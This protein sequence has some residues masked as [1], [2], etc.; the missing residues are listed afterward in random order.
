MGVPVPHG[1]PELPHRLLLHLDVLRAVHL[2]GRP[3][4]HVEA[5]AGAPRRH[6]DGH[7]VPRRRD[8]Q[9]PRR[10]RGAAQ[11][12]HGFGFLFYVLIIASLVIAAALF[13]VAPMIKRMLASRQPSAPIAEADD[14]R[15]RRQGRRVVK[16]S[17]HA[18]L[19]LARVTRRSRQPSAVAAK[20]V[21]AAD[22]DIAQISPSA[23]ARDRRDRRERR[24]RI[25]RLRR[26][27]VEIR[28][29]MLVRRCRGVRMH[30][31]RRRIGCRRRRQSRR[32]RKVDERS[33]VD[34]P[35]MRPPKCYAG[36]EAA[37]DQGRSDRRPRR[38]VRAVA[39]GS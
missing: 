5:R 14:E 28:E 1:Q 17:L 35:S 3:V 11:R 19:A 30:P 20:R 16:Y 10:P 9:L 33:G 15:A 4:E 12:A 22:R 23:K 31:E 29:C 27:P 39:V 24:S 2:A 21:Q 13:A 18:V 37:D 32:S 36:D 38:E 6:G 8:R 34:A 7:V 25:S 26:E